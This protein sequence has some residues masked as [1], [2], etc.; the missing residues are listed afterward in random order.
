MKKITAIIGLAALAL[1]SFIGIAA[2][3]I[4]VLPAPSP[5][6][7]STTTNA[8]QNW[9]RAFGSNSVIFNLDV[10]NVTPISFPGRDLS[11]E[12]YAEFAG[13]VGGSCSTSNLIVRFTY[14]D[15]TAHTVP[16]T[17]T[18]GTSANTFPAFWTM[19]IPVTIAAGV[20]SI[21]V[22]T[23][24]NNSVPPPAPSTTHKNWYVYDVQW[25]GIT[26][27]SP[28]MTNL[29]IYVNSK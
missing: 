25:A 13:G 23:N 20:G 17:T 19:T 3:D 6:K 15:K 9:P 18:N 14:D 24:L 11:L 10:T 4:G 27:G 29:A 26:N 12:F 21:D 7:S 22:I 28:F 5:V 2:T 8:I 16:L 1:V